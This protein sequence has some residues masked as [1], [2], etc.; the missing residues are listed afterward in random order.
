M[1]SPTPHTVNLSG[2][3]TLYGR[4]SNGHIRAVGLSRVDLLARLRNGGEHSVVVK[5]IVLGDDFGR[6]LLEVDVE[7][8]DACGINT[9]PVG[10]F[11]F[12]HCGVKPF[13]KR[14]AEKRTIEFLE[15]ALDS[16]GTSAAAHSYVE[17]VVVLRHDFDI[18]VIG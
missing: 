14:G 1:K 4:N 15:D 8:L 9:M 12:Q 5:G 11:N 16:A 10:Q 18:R 13:S 17:L 6:L 3:K 7:G 2:V